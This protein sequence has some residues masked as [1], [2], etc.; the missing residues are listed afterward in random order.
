MVRASALSFIKDNLQELRLTE[1]MWVVE[2]VT[3]K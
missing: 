3:V 2:V 1:R